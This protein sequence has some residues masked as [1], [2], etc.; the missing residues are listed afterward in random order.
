MTQAVND[1]VVEH[2]MNT[3]GATVSAAEVVEELSEDHRVLVLRHAVDD[4]PGASVESTEYV[5]LH[6]LSRSQHHRL[7]PPFQIG[8]TDLRIEM[9][10]GLVLIEHLVF[11]RSLRDNF[12]YLI[13]GLASTSYWNSQP[14]ARSSTRIPATQR[15]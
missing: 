8:R 9:N 3:L 7:M 6:V 1:V 10:V 2:E 11:G 12:L 14:R 4:S 15:P 5:A 13:Q